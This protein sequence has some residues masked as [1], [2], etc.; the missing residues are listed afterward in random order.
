MNELD[1]GRGVYVFLALMS[2]GARGEKHEQG[3]QALSARIDDVV[4]N[5]IDEGNLAVKTMFD[6]PV[7]GL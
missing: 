5:P 6:D 3:P 4:G 7:D 1:E 2:A